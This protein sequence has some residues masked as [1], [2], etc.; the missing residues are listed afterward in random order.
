LTNATTGRSLSLSTGESLSLSTEESPF[1]VDPLKS[2]V[3]L[4][5]SPVPSP[6]R[7]PVETDIAIDP[8]PSGDTNAV[9]EV[10]PF[11]EDFGIGDSP[12]ETLSERGLKWTTPEGA[13]NG[14]GI[15]RQ[16]R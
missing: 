14:A 16:L 5:V 10:K 6:L 2:S 4:E 7:T 3:N 15:S 8:L 9:P 12:R 13:G 1:V 11:S